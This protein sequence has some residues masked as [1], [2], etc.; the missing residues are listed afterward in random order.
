ME[1]QGSICNNPG[2][3]RTAPTQNQTCS[4]LPSPGSA[5][6]VLSITNPICAQSRRRDGRDEV[7]IRF[8][9]A[10]RCYSG[11]VEAGFLRPN[12]SLLAISGHRYRLCS[13]SVTLRTITKPYW[14]RFCPIAPHSLP[15]SNLHKTILRDNFNI[16]RVLSWRQIG[17]Q[18]DGTAHLPR[19]N[20]SL[21]GPVGAA[22]GIF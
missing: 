16:I 17:Q 6:G 20:G 19:N 5:Q 14:M 3:S 8:S 4:G 1:L 21:G 15:V 18:T 10:S 12:S 11:Q 9:Y 13:Q 2:G 7:P 22:A